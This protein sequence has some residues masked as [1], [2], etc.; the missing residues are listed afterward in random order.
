MKDKQTDS[1]L[2][3]FNGV[4]DYMSRCEWP[5]A[6][7][8]P[9]NIQ[10]QSVR[11]IVFD[12]LTSS[13]DVLIVT[14]YASLGLLIDFLSDIV[15]EGRTVR[16]LLGSE[17]IETYKTDFAMTSGN[18]SD[19]MRDYWLHR[20]ISVLLSAKNL[21]IIDALEKGLIQAKTINDG[22][23][24]LHAK[25]YITDQAVTTGSSNFTTFGMKSQIE[26]NV[27]FTRDKDIK[28]FQEAR[29]VGENYWNAGT[30]YSKEL[31]ALL[32]DLLRVVPWPE[33][34]ARAV[35][36]MLDGDW[37]RSMINRTISEVDLWPSQK[38]GL[39]QALIL[40]ENTGSALIADAAGSGKTMLGTYILK[41]L[42]SMHWSR[43]RAR[44]DSTTLLVPKSV[45]NEWD[46]QI[47]YAGINVRLVSHG[48]VSAT[49]QD[50][51][52]A[53]PIR[54]AQILGLDEAHSFMNLSSKR[55]SLTIRNTADSVLLFT[56]TPINRGINDLITLLNYLDPDN[57]SEDDLLAFNTLV[58]RYKKLKTLSP[59]E[60]NTLKG[61]L[62]K[63]MVRR[64]KKDLNKMVDE[65]PDA[66][67]NRLGKICRYPDPSPHT[68]RPD[69]TQADIVAALSIRNLSDQLKGIINL[70][71]TFKY[72]EWMKKDPAWT[73]EK[74]LRSRLAASAGLA[75][76][77]V[78]SCMRS[79]APALMEFLD[80]TQA[81]CKHYQIQAPKK[82]ATGNILK[83]LQGK[84]M[85]Q[86]DLSAPLPDWLQ[87]ETQYSQAL[88]QEI[89][90]YLQIR[91]ALL[92]LSDSREQFKARLLIELL[93]QHG[94]VIAFDAKPLSLIYIE[95]ILKSHE[96]D[97]RTFVAFGGDHDA[98]KNVVTHF[99]LDSDLERVVAL[100]SDSMSESVNLQLASCLIHLD[101][102][103]TV[104]TAEQRI[105]RIERMDSEHPTIDV[106][107]PDEE[108]AFSVHADEQFVSRDQMVSDI[109]G[110]NLVLPETLK[111]ARQHIITPGDLMDDDETDV[112]EIEILE[113]AF[114]PVKD[115]V[116]G[117][118][119][120]INHDIYKYYI[121]V[122]ARVN[123]RVGLVR[124]K[125]PW[126]F[127]AIEGE[128]NSV[129]IW[130]LF[131]DR[132]S[133]IITDL[134]TIA[135]E[136]RIRLDE[137][138]EDI[139]PDTHSQAAI[140]HFLGRLHSL[141]KDLLPRKK[142]RA[143]ESMT[144]VLSK[145]MKTASEQQ[146]MDQLVWYEWILGELKKPP[147]EY[148]LA[149]SKIAET[150]LDLIT[151]YRM[152]LL[153]SKG[154][155]VKPILIKNIERP[156]LKDP[157]PY[158]TLREHFDRLPRLQRAIHERIVSTI[159][160]VA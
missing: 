49:D 112:P 88:A 136:L 138:V 92:S 29:Q 21:V 143:I 73:E 111:K 114:S 151:P 1:Q 156:L 117:E 84:V 98:K 93:N 99:S 15:Q 116:F 6:S 4:R 122:N 125:T 157:I 149:W 19:E 81:A 66:Y 9:I 90:I 40:M 102:P 13:N 133:P 95:H 3:L 128:N 8:M 127:F 41:A 79:S 47:N 113:D 123:S 158:L 55:T 11:Q 105:G 62:S 52:K 94:A 144:K 115:L 18:M 53:I 46:K 26:S 130:A 78:L 155:A 71:A 25:M 80:G 131:K 104:K 60:L 146:N 120:L 12:D 150:W 141:E 76:H 152:D 23:V 59:S 82:Q 75:R 74:Y 58:A 57:L 28:R 20:G 32:Y 38:Q 61:I 27:R 65:D 17:P 110:S 148:S 101:M 108:N 159:I 145:Y 67:R 137:D 16:L 45:L 24:R 140:E 42:Q 77:R 142:L 35:V 69:S 31:A 68:F 96:H 135:S 126:A 83:S 51:H 64:T 56:A 2:A 153:S 48:E 103:T 10:G 160:G 129:P 5:D 72:P 119:P 34:I 87:D 50:H 39:A 109:I 121:D 22:N 44:Q 54:R 70:E 139:H 89:D 134:G 147:V 97:L 14:G 85:P 91:S 132:H 30:D 33:A 37:A 124:A 107:W 100:C 106:Y 43:G 63:F 86:S 36:L 7:H 154:R 118:T